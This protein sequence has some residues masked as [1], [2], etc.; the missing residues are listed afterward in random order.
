LGFSIKFNE[1]EYFHNCAEIRFLNSGNNIQQPTWRKH[2]NTSLKRFKINDMYSIK[3]IKWLRYSGIAEGI[4][5]LLLFFVG[6]PLKYFADKPEAVRITGTIHGILFVIYVVTLMQA[7]LVLRRP[8]SWSVKI[9]VAAIIP[10]GPFMIEPSL[11]REQQALL[12]G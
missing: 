2:L 12:K 3:T 4:S 6:M 5:S 8:L 7:A 9:F 1:Y 10:M 11:K